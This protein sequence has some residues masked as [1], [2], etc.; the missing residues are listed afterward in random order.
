[1][2]EAYTCLDNRDLYVIM[3]NI[4]QWVHQ[5]T[6]SMFCLGILALTEGRQI[7]YNLVKNVFIKR[8]KAIE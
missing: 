7:Q 8:Y 4:A 2:T 3:L 1:M 6:I 5:D